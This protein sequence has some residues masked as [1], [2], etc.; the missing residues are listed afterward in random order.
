MGAVKANN[1]KDTYKATAV[2]FIV[3]GTLFLINKLLPFASIGL[4]WVMNKDNLLLYASICFLIFKRDK[5]VGFVLL[6]LWLV[7]NIGL[8]M[9]LLGS[10]S[11]YLLPLA[12]LIIGII[13]FWVSKRRRNNEKKYRRYTYCVS[14]CR[15]SGD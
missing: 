3:I 11:G 1:N 8:V 15:K 5:S 10:L 14:R 9:S 7:M 13:L 6:G 12:L 2:T 4:S